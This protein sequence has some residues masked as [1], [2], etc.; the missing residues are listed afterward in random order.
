M[1][2]PPLAVLVAFD[3]SRDDA[4]RLAQ[5]L[6]PAVEQT[7][8]GLGQL[9]RALGG[10]REIGAPLG[11]DDALFFES[12]EHAVEVPDVDSSLVARDLGKQLDQLVAV[13]RPLTQE[14]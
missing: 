5:R 7:D 8:S 1:R 13:H 12:P 2:S 11:G 9:V 4:L 6:D 3:E 14:Q 10:P